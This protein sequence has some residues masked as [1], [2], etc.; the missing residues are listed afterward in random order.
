MQLRYTA[1]PVAKHT[2]NTNFY[3]DPST[4]KNRKA[5]L[6]ALHRGEKYYGVLCTCS[7]TTLCSSV[8]YRSAIGP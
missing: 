8:R 1:L 2:Q 3:L 6:K 4:E 5:Y 7:E